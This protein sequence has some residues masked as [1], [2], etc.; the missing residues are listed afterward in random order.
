MFYQKKELRPA[1]VHTF[2]KFSKSQAHVAG[3]TKTSACNL[4][5]YK[6]HTTKKGMQVQK[7]GEKR[8]L[9]CIKLDISIY[10]YRNKI[11]IFKNIIKE[12]YISSLLSSIVCDPVICFV[13]KSGVQ[14]HINVSIFNVFH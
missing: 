1:M 3:N 8:K 14:V 11:R 10:M 6:L 5:S 4:H 7:C 9:V 2:L 12:Q 13:A